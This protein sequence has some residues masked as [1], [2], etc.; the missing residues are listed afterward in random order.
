[1]VCDE[2]TAALDAKAGRTVMDLLRRVALQ[3]DRAVV[4]VTH[5]SRVYEFGDRIVEMSDGKVVR[6]D[7]ARTAVHA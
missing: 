5:D 6:V 1:L 2:P 7:D 4:V 3:P